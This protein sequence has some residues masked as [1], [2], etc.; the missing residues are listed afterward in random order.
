[1]RSL[2]TLAVLSLAVTGG[3]PTALA[4]GTPAKAALSRAE[5]A[6]K[7][8]QPDAALTSVSTLAA[9]P[10]GTAPTWS[11]LFHSPK[12]K[13]G[14]SVDVRGAKVETLEVN[15]YVKDP[16]GDFI[17]SDAAMREAK[18]NGLK[19]GG[20]LPMGMTVMGQAGAFWTVG[21]PL[22]AGDVAVVLEA[23]TGSLVTRHEAK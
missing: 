4:G 9:N 18:K 1:M 17:D 19:G 2:A 7:A 6:A 14:Y 13:K 21:A 22:K 3:P 16:V 20:P 15:H 12:A 10:D 5:A 23:K 8:W 11:F